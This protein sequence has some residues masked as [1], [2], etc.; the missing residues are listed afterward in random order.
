VRLNNANLQVMLDNLLLD[1]PRLN[2]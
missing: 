1:W 2:A